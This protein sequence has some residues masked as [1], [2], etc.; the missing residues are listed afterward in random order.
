MQKDSNENKIKTIK[1]GFNNISYL[2]LLEKKVLSSIEKK[3]REFKPDAQLSNL[4]YM[5]DNAKIHTKNKDKPEERSAYTI[6]AKKNIEIEDWPEYSPDLN[7]AEN[8]WQLIDNQKNIIL[9]KIGVNPKNKEE[10]FKLIKKAWD[11]VD[12]N[13]VINCY[14]SFTRRLSKVIENNGNNNFDT[15]LK[16]NNSKLF[17]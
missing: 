15:K 1:T 8:V 6:L 5:Q 14:D 2:N 3:Y 17:I 16:K 9:D 11:L 10:S 12:N 13:K 4:I 7:P